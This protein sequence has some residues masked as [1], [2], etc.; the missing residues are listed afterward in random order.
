MTEFFTPGK[1]ARVWR[2]ILAVLTSLM[3]LGAAYEF[4]KPNPEPARM[5]HE[6]SDGSYVYLDL[7]LL[8]NWVYRVTGDESYTFY[9]AMD[10]DENWFIVSLDQKTFDSLQPYQDAYNAYFTDGTMNY[11]YPEPHRLTG[12]TNPITY[13][14]VAQLASYYDIAGTQVTDYFGPNYLNAGASNAAEGAVI[15]LTG[16]LVFGLLLLAV[17]TQIGSVQRNFKKSDARLYELGQLDDAEAQFSSP[18]STRFDKAKLILSA[19]FVFCGASGWVLPYGDIGWLYM[20]R[21]RS[22]GVTVATHLVA[23]LTNG[24]TVY[25]AHRTVD[26]ALVTQTAQTVLNKN[27]ACLI[28]YSFENIKLYNQR[29]K[30]YKLAHPKK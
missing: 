26:D 23:G 15:Y 25:L 4:S 21:Q 5:T 18:D 13:D 28:G 16:V 1:A 12:M 24:K 29:V 8:S 20:R 11:D 30:E 10:S 7:Q 3:I 6:T 2:I 9:E 27:P 19:D 17:S 14:D 22:Y